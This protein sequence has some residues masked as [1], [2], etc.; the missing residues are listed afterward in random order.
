[1]NIAYPIRET[2]VIND[3]EYPLN[4]SFDNILRLFDLIKDQNITD[5]EKIK[6]GL[7]MLIE[8]TLEDHKLEDRANIFRELFKSVTGTREEDKQVLVDIEGNPMPDISETDEKTLDLV[9]DAEF[10]YASFMYCYQIDLFE[11]HG[12]LHWD[13]FKA[14][15]NGLSEDSIFG[16]IVGIRSAEIP[17]G[18]GTEKEQERL[19]KLKRRY[20]IKEDD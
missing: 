7:L 19:R 6:I 17:T 1:M 5:K 16:R 9:Q 2:A 18:K 12:K 10:I 20:A 13:K 14:L 3:T 15:L 4:M 8:D 11:Q